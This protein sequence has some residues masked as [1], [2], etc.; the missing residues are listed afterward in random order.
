MRLS[1]KAL[2]LILILVVLGCSTITAFAENMGDSEITEESNLEA[3]YSVGTIK[4]ITGSQA[5]SSTEILVGDASLDGYCDCKDVVI[6]Q[7]YICKLVTLSEESLLSANISGEEKV[8]LIDVLLLQKYIASGKRSAG[9][10]VDSGKR[11]ITS[12]LVQS[13]NLSSN[14]AAWSINEKGYLKANVVPEHATNTAV[15]WT[16]SNTKIAKV[17]ETGKVTPVA[18]GT[19]TITCTSEE[20]NE[21]FD[22]CEVTIGA[23][24]KKISLNKTSLKWPIGS[25]G[26]FTAMVEPSNAGNKELSWATSN[27]DVATISQNGKLTSVGVGKCTITCASTDGSGVSVTCLVE[28]YQQVTGITVSGT[29]KINVGETT[30]LKS[31]VTPPNAANK[32]INWSTSDKS[33]ATVAADGTVTGRGAGA[34]IITATAADNCG[35]ASTYKVTVE[36][37]KGQQIA[38][39]A[40]KWVGVTPYVWGGTSLK[41]GVDCSGFVCAVYKDCGYDLWSNRTTL[42]NVGK[43]VSLAKAVPGDIVVFYGHVGIYAGNGKVTHALNENY[44]T[45]TT[46]LSWGGTVKCVRRVV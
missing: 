35:A 20:N 23:P 10:G 1:K 30:V 34:A 16:S 27:S 42:S 19:C 7:K 13:I 46:D 2:S 44:G 40:A 41:T 9:T 26:K 32:S 6:I 8:G 14:T 3:C 17:D 37:S 45:K 11:A 38:D 43:E 21:I 15:K 28:V 31:A 36:K 22:K 39:Y 12:Y 29:N 33:V 5:V 24:V 18:I 25:S 4:P